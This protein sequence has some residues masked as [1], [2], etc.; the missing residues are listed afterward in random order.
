MNKKN[1]LL[2]ISRGQTN[3]F[4]NKVYDYANKIF[5]ATL[6]NSS[7]FFMSLYQSTEIIAQIFFN[8]IGGLIADFGNR[9]KILIITDII[10]SI[11]TFIAFL[12]LDLP[13]SVVVL[14]IVN[15]TLAILNSFNNP[16]YKAIVRDLLDK[17]S[18]Y[19]YNSY[20]RSIAEIFNIIVP[21]LGIWIIS[22]FGFK[23]SMLINSLSFAISAII[24]FKFDIKKTVLEN[25]KNA[26]TVGVNKSVIEGF[27]YIFKRK[28]LFI[29]LILVSILNFF[30]AGVDLYLPYLN[31]FFNE[32]YV[33]G[34]VLVSQTIGKIIGAY[35]NKFFRNNFTMSKCC[36][37]LIISSVI[38]FP[39][40]IIKDMYLIIFLFGLSSLFIMI[41]D[42]QIFSK[43]QSEISEEFL[44]R[45][46]STVSLLSLVLYPIGTFVFSTLK[47]NSVII[48]SIISILQVLFCLIIKVLF[49]FTNSQQTE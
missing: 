24:E 13:N 10:A 22:L 45:V 47:I 40:F 3:N 14:V 15:I 38:L 19:I 26:K 4:G 5:I 42:V 34:Y 29:I 25:K 1:I 6:P 2:L 12:F 49:F 37:F 20:S 11:S 17:E 21:F 44:G 43:I 39:I 32:S 31:K 9:K 33:Y 48:F 27:K 35:I 41:F 8:L 18:I 7:M 46:F 36:N 16:A 28:D 23:V 30:F